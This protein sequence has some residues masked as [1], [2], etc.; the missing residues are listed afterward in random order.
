[1]VIAVIAGIIFVLMGQKSIAK[2]LVLGSVFSVINFIFAVIE[3]RDLC[4][5]LRV[6]DTEHLVGTLHC[7]AIVH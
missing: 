7:F 2:G 6:G 3:A 4:H 5:D 1:M